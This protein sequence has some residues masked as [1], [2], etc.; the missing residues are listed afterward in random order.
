MTNYIVSSI[1]RDVCATGKRVLLGMAKLL[2]PAK[3]KKR[4]LK[5]DSLVA[6]FVRARRNR[7]GYTQ[8][9]FAWRVGVGLSFI[10]D[11]EQGK[12]SVRLDKVN[13]VLNFLGYELGPAA[14]KKPVL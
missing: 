13:A 8:E 11:L 6:S 12:T 3:R 7:L 14:I 4:L 9:Q 1:I 5:R 10:R 2:A